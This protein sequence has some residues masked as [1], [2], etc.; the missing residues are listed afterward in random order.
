[1][2]QAEAKD[3]DMSPLLPFKHFLCVPLLQ[4]DGKYNVEYK[5]SGCDEAGDHTSS[6]RIGTAVD[7]YAHHCYEDSN[8]TL[9]FADLQGII[10]QNDE[11]TLFDPQMHMYV[12]HLY[13][14]FIWHSRDIVLFTR[15]LSTTLEG[16]TAG[17]DKGMNGVNDFANT[18]KC[19]NICLKLG[20]KPFGRTT[21]ISTKRKR[22]DHR[23]PLTHITNGRPPKKAR[24]IGMCLICVYLYSLFTLAV[25]ISRYPKL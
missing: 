15:A 16:P 2:I 21:S 1:V 12:S 22:S 5:F 9:V 11:V 18:H 8:G 24:T 3:P 7:A 4:I 10:G 25:M 20:L 6:H 23:T 13:F 14:K 17:W 19:N